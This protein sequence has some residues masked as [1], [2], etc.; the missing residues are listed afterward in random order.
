[1][2][3]LISCLTMG[4]YGRYVWSAYGLVGVVFATNIISIIWQRRQT[5]RVLH[6]WFN[7]S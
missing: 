2:M 6:R 5:Y 1:M 3:T 4:G 7:I